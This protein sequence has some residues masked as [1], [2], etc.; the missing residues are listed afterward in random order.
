MSPLKTFFL[1]GLAGT[2]IAFMAGY[3]MLGAILTAATMF[4]FILWFWNGFE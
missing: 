1:V 2:V 3:D 4:S